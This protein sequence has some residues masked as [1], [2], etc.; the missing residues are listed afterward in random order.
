MSL[1]RATCLQAKAVSSSKVKLLWKA[2]PIEVGRGQIIKY[3]FRIFRRRK[4]V[5]EFVLAHSQF[6]MY[7]EY[8]VE[9]LRPFVEYEFKI[10]SFPTSNDTSQLQGEFPSTDTVSCM[11]KEEKPSEPRNLRVVNATQDSLAVRWKPPRS[12]NGLLR[13]YRLYFDQQAS[14]DYSV[15]E[16][17]ADATS[18]KAT[19]LFPAS[20]YRFQLLAFTGAG[21]GPLTPIVSHQTRDSALNRFKTLGLHNISTLQIK[22]INSLNVICLHSHTHRTTCTFFLSQN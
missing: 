19:F 5:S 1:P 3:S 22:C 15:V 7:T 11:T 13:G 2:P 20:T 10:Q 4:G 8:V 17:S 14:G 18:Y 16:I 12:L 9:N 6:D 21:E